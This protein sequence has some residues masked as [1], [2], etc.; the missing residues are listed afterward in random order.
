MG[1][2]YLRVQNK[3]A[4]ALALAT[5]LPLGVVFTIG[6]AETVLEMERGVHRRA[7]E[8]ASI[9]R[10][11]LLRRAQSL[12][13][14]TDRI[15][16]DPE[17]APLL[18][19]SGPA[20][21]R[22]LESSYG[23]T[24][25]GL[26]EVY[27]PGPLR[28]TAISSAAPAGAAG[29]QPALADNLAIARGL[30]YQRHIGLERSGDLLVVRAGAPVLDEAY[31]VVGVVLVTV[32]LDAHLAELIKGVV[33]AEVGFLVGIEAT[34]STNRQGLS[35]PVPRRLR[36]A[37]RE[38]EVVAA[39]GGVE[40]RALQLAFAPLQAAP[41][42]FLGAVAVGLSRDHIGAARR[43]AA[44]YLGLGSVVGIGLA[45]LFAWLLGRNITR[46]LERLHRSARAVERGDL[47]RPVIPESRDEIGDLARGLQQMIE[48]LRHHQELE[49]SQQQR[50]EQEVARRT[51]ELALA[52]EKL[53][54]LAR[55]DGLTSLANHRH[56]KEQLKR[57]VERCRRTRLPLSLLMIDVDH[58]KHYNDVNGHPA[59]DQA[60]RVV[61]QN[62]SSGRR[63]NDLVA[64][65]GG[66]EFAMLLVDTPR[67][68]AL[69]LAEQ[70]R[71]KIEEAEV[72]HEACQPGG[73]LTVS[74]GAATCPDH[75]DDPDGLVEAADDALYRAK[76]S[77]RNRVESVV[78]ESD[79]KDPE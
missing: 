13:H 8:V 55:T 10:N 35:A 12:A 29:A 26:L 53:E 32:P 25:P 65:Y 43:S 40:G 67:G 21:A 15:A 70:L 24:L 22:H 30:A 50:L 38:G 18:S 64:R 60:L 48:A 14:Y 16:S 62:L 46:P 77:G 19:A 73:R 28:V 59:G 9:A 27:V 47:R 74:I 4:I 11:V 1:R 17:L 72:E 58:F 66:E 23:L 42:A 20:L 41:G 52:N 7:R 79:E 69:E 6:L 71:R 68:A 45:W 5:L 57:E 44:I 3:L 2:L 33:Q 49:R 39:R 51:E 76:G 63:V 34:V 56:F 61:A 31:R 54:A 36:A 37:L 78:K 75:A